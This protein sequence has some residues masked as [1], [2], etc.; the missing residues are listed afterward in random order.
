[1]KTDQLLN[2]QEEVTDALDNFNR[3]S[4]NHYAPKMMEIKL[5]KY[6]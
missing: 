4:V 3:L 2:L 6:F 1:M 5:M